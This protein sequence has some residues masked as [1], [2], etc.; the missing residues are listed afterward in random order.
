MDGLP[1]SPY[2]DL[3]N[4]PILGIIQNLTKTLTM[5]LPLVN[6]SLPS[7]PTVRIKVIYVKI[8]VR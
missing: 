7:I 1:K 3:L 2:E 6:V 4:G 8:F 5:G